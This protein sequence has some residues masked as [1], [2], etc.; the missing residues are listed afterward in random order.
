MWPERVTMADQ[1]RQ[2]VSRIPLFSSLEPKVQHTIALL[3]RTKT[4]SAG[5]KVFRQ[6]DAA[7]PMFA[8][9]TGH[10][11]VV[12]AGY[13]GK[14]IVFAIV[15]PGEVFGELSVLDGAPRSATI[16]AVAR[17]EVMVIDRA[18]FIE[19]LLSSPKVAIGLLEVL[20][21]RVRRLSD[22]REDMASLDV[23]ARLAKKLAELATQYGETAI[24]GDLRIA[25]RLTQRDLGA[26]VGTTRE[27]VNKFLKRWTREGLLRFDAGHILV[28]DIA[29][30]KSLAGANG[31]P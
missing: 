23:S 21:A 13:D 9:L 6:G 16:T 17:T 15:G 20:A 3:A 19:F 31:S 22:Q 7:G 5:Q 24:N 1:L 27:T 18:P 4:Y 10:L 26:W 14:E 28:S 12:V 30:L 2:L 25:L 11:K 8:V 29:R